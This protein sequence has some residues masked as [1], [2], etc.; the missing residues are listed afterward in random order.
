MKG[1]KPYVSSGCQPVK[2]LLFFLSVPTDLLQ[3]GGSEYLQRP[4]YRGI[5]LARPG[6]TVQNLIQRN[7]S[8]QNRHRRFRFRLPTPYLLTVDKQV[9]FSAPIH[10]S[11]IQLRSAQTRPLGIAKGCCQPLAPVYANNLR[12][13][14]VLIKKGN[15]PCDHGP[16][17][18]GR[19][20]LQIS[21]LHGI[22]DAQNVFFDSGKGFFRGV[23]QTRSPGIFFPVS[24]PAGLFFRKLGV[25]PLI[26]A[27]LEGISAP[28]GPQLVRHAFQTAHKTALL[29]QC[30]VLRQ[31]HAANF[32]HR[33]EFKKL[34]PD[35]I[36]LTDVDHNFLP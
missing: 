33:P 6:R 9:P 20:G 8:L 27:E 36:T 1:H 15:L 16:E 5:R 28:D 23:S 19:Y 22:N 11:A 34:R 30:V 26:Y 3:S 25:S 14:S 31:R 13:L 4:V 32:L 7:A 21:G 2:A 17:R 24:E 12:I 18:I 10:E 29:A 35:G